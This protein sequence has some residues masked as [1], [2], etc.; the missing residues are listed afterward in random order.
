MKQDPIIAT[1]S[2]LL[3]SGTIVH[4]AA[5][6]KIQ[7]IYGISIHPHLVMVVSVDR[8]PDLSLGKTLIWKTEIGHKLVEAVYKAITVPF[9]W[10]WVAEGVLALLLEIRSEQ[11]DQQDLKEV[12]FQI[13]RDIQTSAYFMDIPVSIG[14]GTYYDNPYMLHHSYDEAKRSMVDRFFQG[15]RLIFQFEKKSSSGDLRNDPVVRLER[16]ELLAR[17]RIG[18]GEGTVSILK[19]LMERMARAYKFNVDMFKSEVADLVM[20]MSRLALESGVSAP[21]ILSENAHFIQDLYQTIRY[22]KFVQK[23]CEYGQRLTEQ[24][25]LTHSAVVSPVIRQAIQYIK[26][27]LEK[28]ISLDEIARFCCLSKYH[29]SHLFKKELGVSI[30]DFINKMRIEKAL[31]YLEQTDLT[32]QQIANHVG[33]EDANYFSRTFKKYVQI[34]PS[35]FR[36]TKI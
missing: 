7:E 6:S 15:N 30:V 28:K 1:F 16:T 36:S 13:A 4:E 21:T 10:A 8:Y 26:E 19:I 20:L 3:L 2:H 35:E 17:V 24:V 27:N 23:V 18:D 14:I 22:D 9:V 31:L 25:T 12:N 34:S 29:I 32:V 33:F 11:L 5:F